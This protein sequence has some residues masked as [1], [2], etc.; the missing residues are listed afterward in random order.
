MAGPS[1]RTTSRQVAASWTLAYPLLALEVMPACGLPI[2][3]ARWTSPGVAPSACR[4]QISQ[5]NSP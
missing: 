5:L 2:M 1:A 3:S 4:S